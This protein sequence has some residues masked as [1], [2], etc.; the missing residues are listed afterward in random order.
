M[1]GHILQKASGWPLTPVL[2]LETLQCY[3]LPFRNYLP[4]FGSVGTKSL[5]G[6]DEVIKLPHSQ[7]TWVFLQ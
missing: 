3:K 4:R 6:P 1:K 2:S 7:K 5:C